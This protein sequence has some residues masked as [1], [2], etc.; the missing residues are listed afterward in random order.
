MVDFQT[1]KASAAGRWPEILQY[2][3]VPGESLT[4]K[5][6]PCPGCSG[7]DRFRYLNDEN[8]SWICGQ[9][10]EPTG[11]DGFDLLRHMGM[12]T[13]A[14]LNAVAR[15]LGIDDRPFTELDRRR[16]AQQ[17]R[18]NEKTRIDQGRKIEA[19]Y[20]AVAKKAQEIWKAASNPVDHGYLTRKQIDS[21][22]A[23]QD[24]RALLVAAYYQGKIVNIQHISASGDKWWLKD[25]R[26]KGVYA[27]IGTISKH[28]YVSEG[29]ATGASLYE[30]T[31]TPAA[32]AFN[33]NNLKTVA[34]SMRQK[35]PDVEIVI[36]CDNDWMKSPNKGLEM[37]RQAAAAIGCNVFYPEFDEGQ[38]KLS[39]WN[40]YFNNGGR[41]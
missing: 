5:H 2:L 39:D 23:R 26:T 19:G 22:G 24:G 36:A 13:T 28:L 30:H 11:G 32:I 38:G 3:G 17:K 15:H 1:V 20:L 12:D 35:Y 37:G 29:F 18:D 16:I 9:G 7:K 40:D 41:L 31:G 8:G 6:C 25:G 21:H 33:A 14:A 27:A 10:G 4:G 34:V